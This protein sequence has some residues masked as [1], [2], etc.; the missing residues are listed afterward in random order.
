MASTSHDVAAAGTEHLQVAANGMAAYRAPSL[1]QPH[2][3]RQAIRDAYEGKIAPL[4]GF[5][6][7]F[8]TVLTARVIAQIHADWVFIDWEHSSCGVETMTDVSAPNHFPSRPSTTMGHLLTNRNHA[9]SSMPFS[10]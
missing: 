2:K 8:P 9:R 10:T 4:I 6:F 7:A 3:A 1:S 5:F